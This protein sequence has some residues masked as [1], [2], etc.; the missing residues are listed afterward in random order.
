MANTHKQFQQYLDAIRLSSDKRTSLKISRKANRKRIKT[1]FTEV[2]KKSEPKFYGQGSYMMHTILNPLES[3]EYDL[4]DGV[5][6]QGLGTDSTEWPKAET[7]QGW[8]ADAVRGYTKEEPQKK[9]RCV[10]VRYQDAGSGKYHIDLPAYVLNA[11]GVP[12]LFERGKDLPTESDPKSFT[13]WFDSKASSKGKQLRFIVRYLKGWRDC[14]KGDARVASGLAL[15]ILA[16]EKFVAHER[17]DQAFVAVVKAMVSH[18]ECGGSICKP[19][20]PY[21]DLTANWTSDQRQ[22]F[23]TALK[24]LRDDGQDALD[25]SDEE[26]SAATKIWNRLFGSRFPIVEDDCKKSAAPVNIGHNFQRSA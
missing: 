1:H 2:L 11:Q 23:I 7:V 10:R 16:A 13:E 19:V 8:I 26:I 3:G 21:E 18:L 4:D 25:A 15:S 20:T 6:L 17:D 5:Y 14:K 22:K 12:L 24:K 9:A